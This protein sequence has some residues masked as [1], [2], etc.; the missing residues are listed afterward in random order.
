MPGR[1]KTRVQ[2]LIDSSDEENPFV[3]ARAR[4]RDSQAGLILSSKEY[5]AL[6]G[7]QVRES[8]A[9]LKEALE[10]RQ[11]ARNEQAQA[12]RTLTA[13]HALRVAP[14]PGTAAEAAPAAAG[15]ADD[16]EP[17]VIFI[18]G[19]PPARLRGRGRGAGRSGSRF[20]AARGAAAAVEQVEEDALP[21]AFTPSDPDLG[22]D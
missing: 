14:A 22:V 19:A 1:P 18:E 21:A 16:A 9:Q 8:R 10:P 2:R 13:R 15:V 20:M 17:D 7:K 11:V 4:A 5:V 12:L 6:A 3:R